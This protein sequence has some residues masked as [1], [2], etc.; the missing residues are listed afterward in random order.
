M[1]ELEKT[2]IE[3]LSNTRPEDDVVS[4][5]LQEGDG[6]ES[7]VTGG[8]EEALTGDSSSLN[9]RLT[10]PNLSTHPPTT[11]YKN[12]NMDDV[13]WTMNDDGEGTLP[14]HVPTDVNKFMK[15][16]RN[17]S[18][19]QIWKLVHRYR[20][21]VDPATDSSNNER[22]QSLLK[23]L[24]SYIINVHCENKGD[25]PRCI[26]DCLMEHIIDLSHSYPLVP[27]QFLRSL[28]LNISDRQF[29]GDN[30]F[31]KTNLPLNISQEGPPTVC[32]LA[33]I[34][35]ATRLYSMDGSARHEILTPII[36]LLEIWASDHSNMVSQDLN[37]MVKFDGKLRLPP[38][39][40]H[41]CLT[42]SA[43]SKANII[44]GLLHSIID[45]KGRYSPALFNV[46]RIIL[47]SA[48]IIDV[49]CPKW[50]EWLKCVIKGVIEILHKSLKDIE[51]NPG[52]YIPCVHFILPSLERLKD[53]KPPPKRLP[54]PSEFQALVDFSRS[55]SLRSCSPC[56]KHKIILGIRML[57]PKYSVTSHTDKKDET[58]QLKSMMTKARRTA[59]RELRKDRT[60][61]S[62]VHHVKKTQHDKQIAARFKRVKSV[63][64]SDQ[65]EYNK[66]KT[67]GGG[68]EETIA[69]NR[70]KKAMK[71]KK[72]KKLN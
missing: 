26:M 3:R 50:E 16:L 24:L 67:M 35:L 37:P 31:I 69:A 36:M 10:I 18:G 71:G 65:N 70:V 47:E 5:Y 23:S 13:D 45:G 29:R 21:I 63:L 40:S 53:L 7:T 9:G 32:D 34:R 41:G 8:I 15:L 57:T 27:Y 4:Q 11:V 1:K 60:F 56:S 39:V 52:C 58:R 33:I 43:L 64:D 46:C 42:M 59:G 38:P 19:I 28:L 48:C 17:K 54:P 25:Y 6:H 44:G 62:A 72:T 22:L 49:E 66:L 12:M 51:G 30:T 61:I 20:A 68:M 14:Y 2:R 55:L